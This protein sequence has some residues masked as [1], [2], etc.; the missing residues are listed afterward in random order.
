MVKLKLDI[1]IDTEEDMTH[2]QSSIVRLGK[3]WG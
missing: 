3:A 1:D 2:P